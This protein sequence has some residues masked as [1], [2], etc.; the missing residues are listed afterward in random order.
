MAAPKSGVASVAETASPS[1]VEI[2][3]LLGVFVEVGRRSEAAEVIPRSDPSIEE[4]GFVQEVE[5]KYKEY[6]AKHRE[7]CRRFSAD[8]KFQSLRDELKEKD[9]EL[10]RVE[11]CSELEGDLK[12]K[13]DELEAEL[14]QSS[15][16]ANDLSDELT[17]KTVEL[18]RAEEART[19]T[20]VRVAALEEVIRVL[21]SERASEAKTAMLREARVDERI[22][23]LKREVSSLSDQVATLEAEKAHL[24]ARLSSSYT[25]AFS[26]VLQHLYEMWIHAEAQ[27]DILKNLMTAGK[28]P[29]ADF[30]DARVKASTPRA[31]DSEEEEELDELEQDAWYE[32]EHPQGD[33]GDSAIGM[34]GEGDDNVGGDSVE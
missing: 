9:D 17:E 24:L 6:R 2:A 22:G 5:S 33:G 34:G 21:R 10:V 16:R 8:G 7:L 26:D 4:E 20:L 19:M 25:S 3:S 1:N 18:E 30:E 28:V 32:D 29:E 14:E 31:G 23:G 11:R 27:L 12:A 13:D 15:I